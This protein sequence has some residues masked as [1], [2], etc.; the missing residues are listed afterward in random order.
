M[1]QSFLRVFEISYRASV[2][3]LI[4]NYWEMTVIPELPDTEPSHWCVNQISVE[5]RGPQGRVRF[6]DSL[7][8]IFWCCYSLVFLTLFMNSSNPSQNSCLGFFVIMK[9]DSLQP[10]FWLLYITATIKRA[11]NQSPPSCL[12][13]CNS[14]RNC[15]KMYVH[16]SKS[17]NQWVQRC[18]LR[19][20]CTW[21]LVEC[22]YLLRHS[23]SLET[24]SVG[25]FFRTW[26]ALLRTQRSSKEV[27]LRWQKGS[28][29]L[30]SVWEVF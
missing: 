29:I 21:H 9:N 2:L 18:S 22:V 7:D 28:G 25:I 6:A 8:L 16:W 24:S 12:R 19:Y 1:I 27:L 15:L 5:E 13:S 17:I 14:R 30:C 10:T 3:Q 20:E 23:G 26:L 4:Q 11:W